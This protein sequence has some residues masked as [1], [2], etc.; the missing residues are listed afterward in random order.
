MSS[1][2][3]SRFG[4]RSKGDDPSQ[5]PTQ[6][7]PLANP[8]PTS[9]SQQPL[10]FET[11]LGAGS[12][13]EGK[14]KSEGN[15]RLDGI[16]TGTL[17]ISGNVLVGE[18]A[19]I[20]ADIDAKNISIA[21]SVRGNVSGNKVQLLRTGKVW[22]NITATALTTEEGAFID[23]KISMHTAPAS[24][25]VTEVINDEISQND[26]D[27]T[28]PSIPVITEELIVNGEEEDLELPEM[29][30]DDI[31]IGAKDPDFIADGEIDQIIASLKDDN[32]DPENDDDNKDQSE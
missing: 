2:F 1:L 25:E 23:G 8:R 13:L 28:L 9:F 3:G 32:P 29:K 30:D 14:F 12:V 20:T 26:D 4:S 16:F 21:G 10:G 27:I 18:T 19:N 7:R 6:P 11:V 22:G 15:I 17:D 5:E 24:V 31:L